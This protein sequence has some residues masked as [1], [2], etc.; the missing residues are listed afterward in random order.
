MMNNRFKFRGK[1]IDNGEF[2]YGFYFQKRTWNDEELR[3]H[4]ILTIGED[5]Y[6]EVDDRTVCLSTGLLDSNGVEIFEGDIL[7]HKT[8]YEPYKC[9]IE[10]RGEED[11]ASCGC[12]YDSF[13]G[14]G[15][16]GVVI[17]GSKYEYSSLASEYEKMEIIGNKF[18]NPELLKDE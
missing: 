12:C 3:E 4:Y 6:F 18:E 17:K 5:E 2:I 1:R 11:I 10:W 16:V 13:S 15:L 14:V 9:I 8:N 7:E